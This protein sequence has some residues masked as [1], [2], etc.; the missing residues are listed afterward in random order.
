MFHVFSETGIVG[1]YERH[2]LKNNNNIKKARVSCIEYSI[3][4]LYYILLSEIPGQ[5]MNIIFFKL[6]IG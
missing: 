1:H 3:I 2:A 5:Y 6:F 4:I